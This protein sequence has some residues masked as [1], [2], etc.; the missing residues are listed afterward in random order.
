MIIILIA[1]ATT[2]TNRR[3]VNLSDS[4]DAS[5]VPSNQQQLQRDK[6]EEFDSMRFLTQYIG[7]PQT[8]ELHHY[9][10][11]APLT[12]TRHQLQQSCPNHRGKSDWKH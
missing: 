4:D 8:D 6:Q 7:P 2:T 3:T 5:V 12:T 9:T 10:E 11:P 1:H